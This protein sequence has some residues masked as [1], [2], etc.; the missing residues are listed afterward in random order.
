M[1]AASANASGLPETI[2]QFGAGRFLR[3]FVDRF[4]HQA[5]EQGQQVGRI[6]VVQSTAGQR[7]DLLNAQPAGFHVVVRGIQEGETID[8]VEPVGSIS[9]A[10][11]AVDQWSDVL[12]VARSPALKYIV[13]N[14]TEA[15][16]TLA[17]SDTIDATP[18]QAMPAKLTAV[19][20]TRFQARQE[21][22]VLLP[23]EL[24]EGNAPKLRQIVVDLARGW[25]LPAAFVDWL[26]N[27]CVWLENLVDCIVTP[28]PADHPLANE[29]RLLV[30]AEPYMLW[31]IVRPT[32][33]EVRLFDHPAILLVN[34]VSPY[35]LRKVR[36]LNGLHTAMAAKYRPLG[37]QTVLEVMRNR[38]AV[39]WLRGVAFEEIVPTIAHRVEDA[40]L[41]ADQVFERFANPF[42]AH[43][44]ADIANNHEA[45]VAVRLRPTVDEYQKLFG[46]PPRRLSEVV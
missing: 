31:A 12:E 45:K 28:G 27:D 10:L 22:L 7:A 38:D 4:V 23:C 25:Q 37:F 8:R 26:T 44:L 1:S 15:G 6:V 35:Y 29:D 20:W 40:A 30:T 2:L 36:I 24:I 39:R 33:K 11:S 19:L 46:R 41:F 9:R 3:A 13:T 17:Q 32:A 34:D 21:P 42:L 43:R 14:A 16:Y 5:N 18:P